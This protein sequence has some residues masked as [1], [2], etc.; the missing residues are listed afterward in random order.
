MK[1]FTTKEDIE[2]EKYGSRLI[3]YPYVA[4]SIDYWTTQHDQKLAFLLKNDVEWK[5]FSIITSAIE[6]GYGRHYDVDEYKESLKRDGS[7][8]QRFFRSAQ[9]DA[10]ILEELHAR[11]ENQ[12]LLIQEKMIKKYE[13]YLEYVSSYALNNTDN[14]EIKKNKILIAA[15]NV[16]IARSHLVV[17][18][19]LSATFG[20]AASRGI[21][22]PKKRKPGDNKPKYYRSLCD[23]MIASRMGQFLALNKLHGDREDTTY[24]FVT[25][26]NDLST[27][28]KLCPINDSFNEFTEQDVVKTYVKVSPEKELFP[29]LT[30]EQYVKLIMQDL[31]GCYDNQKTT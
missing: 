15:D 19:C 10:L 11:P 16:G 21:I 9:T 27:F 12:S 24:E 31:G 2:S 7:I 30:E 29:D 8:V 14:F 23:I 20:S 1:D 13:S 5:F 4:D 26:D 6:S 17:A 3:R 28:I 25:L 18:I 22:T